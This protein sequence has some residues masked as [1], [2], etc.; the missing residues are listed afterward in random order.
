MHVVMCIE[1][2]I[3]CYAIVWITKIDVLIVVFFWVEEK[4]KRNFNFICNF[5]FF[6][7]QDI[8]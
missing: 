3:K 1:H 5:I 2:N 7:N 4:Y 6:H 8:L